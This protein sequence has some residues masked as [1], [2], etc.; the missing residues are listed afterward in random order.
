MN[1][2]VKQHWPVYETVIIPILSCGHE[3]LE[4]I[5]LTKKLLERTVMRMWKMDDG[6]KED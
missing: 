4:I 2:G 5:R 1:T 6:S 3:I